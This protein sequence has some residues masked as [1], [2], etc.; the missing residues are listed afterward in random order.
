MMMYRNALWLRRI[1]EFCFLAMVVAFAIILPIIAHADT[2]LAVGTFGLKSEK[3]ESSLADLLTTYLSTDGKFDLI[4]R[5]QL[6]KVLNEAGLSL[7]G[8][9]SAGNVVTLGNLIRADKFLLG[10]SI[11][12]NGTN[13]VIIRLVDARTGVIL[14]INAFKDVDSV[15]T[16]A[17]DIATFTAAEDATAVDQHEEFLAIGV[18]QNL[19]VN[20]RFPDFPGQMRGYVAAHLGNKVTLLER[21]VVS[22]LANEMELDKAGL[23]AQNGKPKAEMQFSFWIV[24]GFYQSYEAFTPEVQLKLRIERVRGGQEIAMLQGKP[25]DQFLNKICDSI[26]QTLNHPEHVD[27][28]KAPSR[29]GEL[30]ALEARAAQLCDYDRQIAFL[31]G[32]MK[33]RTADNPDKVANAL[34][35]ATRVFESMLLLD[36]ER[37]SAKMRLA[38]CLLFGADPWGQHTGDNF[39]GRQKRANELYREIIA[40]EDPAYADDARISLAYSC[41]N[42]EAVEMLRRFKQDAT[43]DATRE[44]FSY[45]ANEMLSQLEPHTSKKAA[46]P[47]LRSQLLDE[48]ADAERNYKTGVAV[49]YED[50]LFAYRFQPEEREKIINV[51]I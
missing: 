5:R 17:H 24:D 29:Q 37:N 1:K 41:Y 34:D 43:N 46:F 39:A 47:A 25:D 13:F 10:T 12:V 19:G 22:F 2:R 27:Q 18:V 30:D 4:E 33:M 16:L 3:R 51:R 7:S 9:V 31:P 20:N 14:A 15:D 42:L 32:R 26:K 6:D 48:W 44:E 28:A 38:G 40:T 49:S 11:P 8:H 23:V 50:I 36:P 45:Y 35:E 21:D